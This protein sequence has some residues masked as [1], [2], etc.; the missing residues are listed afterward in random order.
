MRYLTF[1][2]I[3]FLSYGTSFDIAY[4]D[5]GELLKIVVLSRHGVRSP[6]QSKK[7]LNLW[8]QKTWPEWPVKHGDLT[9]RGSQLVTAM[10]Q[11]IATELIKLNILPDQSCPNPRDIY[12][13]A[14][15]DERTRATA[16]AI[17]EGIAP[18]CKLGYAV[19]PNV[20]VD[21]L[22]H[23]LK[24]GLYKFAPINAVTNILRQTNGG[25][26][27]LEDEFSPTLNL[28]SSI[29]GPPDS[30]LCTKFAMV[31][32][33]TL[34]DLPTAISIAPD[35]DSIK[36]MGALDI[37]S[38]VAEIFLLE[39]AQWP[40]EP[41][42]WGQVNGKVLEQILPIHA[43]IFDI[44][45]RAPLIAWANG[46]SLLTEIKT[47]LLN[48]HEDSRANN[49]KLVIFVGH[50]TNIANIG[51]LLNFNWHAKNYPPNGI[52]PAGAIF[53]EL[54]RK[55]GKEYIRSRF[56]AQSP[57]VLHEQFSNT[58]TVQSFAAASSI[59]TSPPIIGEARLGVE[60][61]SLLVTQMTEGA[62]IAP[63]VNPPLDFNRVFPQ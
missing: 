13:R 2:L 48:K 23:P 50:D 24:A 10:W 17:L 51:G 9:P 1:L 37:A 54:W 60:E 33:C 8:S 34:S 43:K 30:T 41:A 59:I 18:N 25:I 38:S 19:L 31:P 49:A 36:F 11:N 56:L 15:V 46:S 3:L 20:K 4:A 7:I 27:N 21:P 57:E 44:V 62:P 61:F 45:N 28:I 12:I 58:D 26:E 16:A 52:P 53:F 63:P 22:F 42:G 39:Y 14:D 6:T 40:N 29:I 35:G 47:A 5:D 55:D 32:N